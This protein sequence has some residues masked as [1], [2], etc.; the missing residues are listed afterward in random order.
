[1][2]ATLVATFSERDGPKLLMCTSAQAA[3]AGEAWYSTQRSGAVYYSAP[4]ATKEYA[5]AARFLC[6]RALSSESVGPDREGKV[7]FGQQGKTFALCYVF[8]VYDV[9]AR[10]M[11]RQYTL[12]FTHADCEVLMGGAAYIGAALR[13]LAAELRAASK[14]VFCAEHRRRV[15]QVGSADYQDVSSWGAAVPMPAPRTRELR[16]L[17]ELLNDPHVM[18][19]LHARLSGLLHA[20]AARPVVNTAS[21]CIPMHTLDAA[22]DPSKGRG[23]GCHVPGTTPHT[24]PERSAPMNVRQPHESSPFPQVRSI[25]VGEEVHAAT[26]PAPHA[27]CRTLMQD[28]VAPSPSGSFSDSRSS[29]APSRGGHEEDTARR[30]LLHDIRAA[31]IRGPSRRHGDVLSGPHQPVGQDAFPLLIFHLA[32]GDQVVVTSDSRATTVAAVHTLA[33]LLPKTVRKCQAY[34]EKYVPGYECNLLGLPR[35]AWAAE[36]GHELPDG[37]VHLAL[38]GAVRDTVKP[39]AAA[40]S[41]NSALARL[42]R[43]RKAEAMYPAEVDQ[44]AAANSPLETLQAARLQLK[45]WRVALLYA[46]YAMATRHARAFDLSSTQVK[47][48]LALVSVVSPQPAADAAIFRFMGVKPRL[49]NLPGRPDA[50][51]AD[52]LLPQHGIVFQCAQVD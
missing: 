38:A 29:Q 51:P 1:M 42:L 4:T 43:L 39:R 49:G 11:Q 45:Y 32:A 44:L 7:V 14:K 33:Q 52:P 19:A 50:P 26:S 30:V 24:S 15:R 2:N 23:D 16:T 8:H 36:V 48:A 18:P 34:S 9:E 46:S 10:G 28:T 41:R 25:S 37:C 35:Q 31:L 21:P 13:E 17:A 6:V 12:V 22:V 40:L 5:S 47:K 27:A 3:L 20:L